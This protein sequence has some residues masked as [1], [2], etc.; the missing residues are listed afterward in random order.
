MRDDAGEQEFGSH[1][2]SPER[3]VCGPHGYAVFSRPVPE[4]FTGAK[5]IAEEA[6]ED[7]GRT[8]DPSVSVCGWHGAAVCSRREGATGTTGAQRIAEEARVCAG[9]TAK[10]VSRE[11]RVPRGPAAANEVS[12]KAGRVR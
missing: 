9:G 5:W 6:R 8:R 4:G 3:A 2:T 7:A 12:C 11:A 1:G 10:R